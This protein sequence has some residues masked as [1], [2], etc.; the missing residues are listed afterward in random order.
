MTQICHSRREFLAAYYTMVA[1]QSA[2]S[3][4]RLGARTQPGKISAREVI[5][6]VAG[7][8]PGRHDENEQQEGR[9]RVVV[10]PTCSVSEFSEGGFSCPSLAALPLIGGHDAKG[11]KQRGAEGGAPPELA[12]DKGHRR[13]G[14]VH[15]HVQDRLQR[16]NQQPS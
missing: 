12:E 7:A 10:V 15:A 8:V 1:R 2:C 6:V 3:S 5:K 16:T 11:G 13:Q 9:V 4:L 14:D